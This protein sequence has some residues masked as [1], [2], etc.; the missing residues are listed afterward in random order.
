MLIIEYYSSLS[1]K[2]YEICS[3]IALMVFDEFGIKEW[4]AWLNQEGWI[5][6]KTFHKDFP[7][8]KFFYK[9][10]L[11]ENHNALHL[12]IKFDTR[13]DRNTNKNDKTKEI[14]HK[15]FYTSSDPLILYPVSQVIQP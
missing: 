3:C 14:M 11:F 5:G 1:H 8:F 13:L 2:I 7:Y 4:V 10:F 9:H 12:W 6:F 15:R